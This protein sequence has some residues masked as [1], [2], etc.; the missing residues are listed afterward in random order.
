MEIVHYTLF[1]SAASS[2]SFI[3]FH[4]PITNDD[5]PHPLDGSNSSRDTAASAIPQKDLDTDSF[6]INKGLLSPFFIGAGLGTTG[7]TA[8]YNAMCLLGFPSVHFRRSCIHPVGSSSSDHPFGSK[9]PLDPALSRS[10]RDLLGKNMYQVNMEAEKSLRE[11]GLLAHQRLLQSWRSL[12]VCARRS[13]QKG[14][15]GLFKKNVNF[16]SSVCGN[17][18]GIVDQLYQHA[19]E[20]VASG[21]AFVTDTPYPFL[22]HFLRQM[23][24]KQRLNAVVLLTERDPQTWVQSRL[25]HHVGESDLMCFAAAH[26]FDLQ[27][28][29]K[30]NE[31]QKLS[32]ET[33][34]T[35]STRHYNLQNLAFQHSEMFGSGNKNNSEAKENDDYRSFLARAM[36]QHH[37]VIKNIT[38]SPVIVINLWIEDLPTVP[39]LSRALRNR[40]R[41]ILS[42][43]ILWQYENATPL[44]SIRC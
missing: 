4:K 38:S 26:G 10:S 19:S 35:M 5:E 29:L 22:F 16:T 21:L 12:R 34:C 11:K 14:E 36:K 31:N 13:R 25:R 1:C 18:A 15:H 32:A 9:R 40:M 23:A 20:V 8:L 6:T 39:D 7:T 42:P 33:D 43:E 44:Q 37:T 28:C 24:V 41:P 17:G 30:R 27:E 2:V 3:P